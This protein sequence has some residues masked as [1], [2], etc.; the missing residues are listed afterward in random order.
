VGFM[1]FESP[2]PIR[3]DPLILPASERCFTPGVRLWQD[4]E[5]VTALDMKTIS[6]NPM[7]RSALS[8]AFSSS[9][10]K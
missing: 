10:S 7:P 8:F 6:S 2:K 4:V 1:G 3:A 9:Q 5:H